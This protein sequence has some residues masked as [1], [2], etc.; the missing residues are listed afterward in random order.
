M[1]S[2]PGVSRHLRVLREAGLVDVEHRAQ[3]RVGSGRARW[4]G[5]ALL[6]LSLTKVFLFDLSKLSS[7][8]RATSFLAVG[9]TL[10]AAGFPVRRLAERRPR[11][12]GT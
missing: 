4:A 8:T 5:V 9:L 12:L 2:R 7:L 3:F 10:L 1:F 11:R 6:A